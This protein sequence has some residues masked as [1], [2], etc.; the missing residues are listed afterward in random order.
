MCACSSYPLPFCISFSFFV[1]QL[2]H[3][4]LQHPPLHHSLAH[5]RPHPHPLSK[6]EKCQITSE[7]IR[8]MLLTSESPE[9]ASGNTFEPCCVPVNDGFI[10]QDLTQESKPGSKQM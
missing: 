7:C 1:P 9:E 2:P 3:P 5:P 4:P 10:G 6:V 8:K